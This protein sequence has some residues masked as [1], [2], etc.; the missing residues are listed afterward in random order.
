MA[1]SRTVP[2]PP[3]DPDL[4][5]VE[6]LFTGDQSRSLIGGFLRDRGWE[7]E[8]LRVSQALYRP[9]RAC[10]VRFSAQARP[11][12]GASRFL[13]ICA[14]I[15]ARETVVADPPPWFEQRIGIANPVEQRGDALVWVFPYDPNLP[16]LPAAARGSMV[17]DAARIARPSAIVATP[18]RYRPGQR[19]AIRYTIVGIG[20]VRET[21]WGKVV[22]EDSFCRIFD[23][24][25]S[26]RSVDVGMVSPRA[27]ESI[28]GL[29]LF[30]DLPGTCLRELIEDGGA[31]P[32]PSRLVQLLEEVAD[33]PWE[34]DR[35]LDR[36]DASLRVSGRLLAHIL[37]GRRGEIQGMYRELSERLAAPLPQIFTV[38]GDLYEGQ[39]FVDKNFQLGIIDLEDGG[40]GDPLLD[41]ANMLAHLT[42][43]H[44]YEPG[45]LGRPLAYRQLLRQR[46]VERLGSGAEAELDWREAAC[47]LHLA[48][49][50]FRVQSP[51][52][53]TETN[54]RLDQI[55]SLMGIASRAAA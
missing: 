7:L 3:A 15:R 26:F 39:I 20:G 54:D 6:K 22:P 35:T 30:P 51:D 9:G 32:D 1:E 25:R 40:L 28:P 44:A 14:R 55:A 46:L 48:T 19:A 49:G 41:A 52:W 36:P 10:T 24:N 21:L 50:P 4:P 5:Q 13:T 42:V 43:L 27:V 2:L 31:L 33:A 34:G 23:A 47:L 18:I 8:G 53:P 17:R 37:P 12:R 29:A 45:A 11:R 16:G 38:H